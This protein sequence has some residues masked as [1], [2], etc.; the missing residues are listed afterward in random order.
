MDENYNENECIA[1]PILSI[2]GA[3]SPLIIN[4][5][6]FIF[7]AD[8]LISPTNVLTATPSLVTARSTNPNSPLVKNLAFDDGTVSK[9]TKSCRIYTLVATQNDYGTTPVTLSWLAGEDFT[10]WEYISQKY[11][12]YPNGT[13]QCAIGFVYVG[14]QSSAVFIPGTTPLDDPGIGLAFFETA[15]GSTTNAFGSILYGG[16]SGV[17][18]VGEVLTSGPTIGYLSEDAVFN[19]AGETVNSIGS[20]VYN[21]LAGG[22]FAV[23][24]TITGVTSGATGV[25]IDD[26]GVG[27]M[28]IYSTSGTAYDLD[29]VIGNGGGQTAV[30]TN[31]YDQLFTATLPALSDTGSALQVLTVTGILAY[32]DK[33]YGLTSNSTAVVNYY[34]AGGA[35]AFVT[36]DDATS[37]LT[38]N[39]M[40]GTF[41]PGALITG[42]ISTDT[43][44]VLYYTSSN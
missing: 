23:G 18:T 22:V 39:T 32:G 10:R 11:M 12:A 2:A 35:T 37:L 24:N 30:I 5:G 19:A 43:A 21:T 6:N 34:D 14:N 17:K 25:V 28:T 8:G 13:N 44:T 15:P 31:Y 7:K 9:K 33:V 42:S 27:S 41:V 40:V 1:Y 4:S 38:I 29:E 16:S 36:A 26:D 3:S 20:I